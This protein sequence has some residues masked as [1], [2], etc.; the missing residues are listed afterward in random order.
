MDDRSLL[1]A[2]LGGM[3]ALGVAMALVPVRGEVGNV[4]VALGLAL[5][6]TAAGAFGRRLG[7]SVTAAVAA[8]SFAFF[9][10][11]PYDTL[12]IDAFRDVLTVVLLFALGVVTGD[13]SARLRRARRQRPDLRELRRLHRVASRAAS[14]DTVEDLTS[15][16]CAELIG[17]LVLHDCWYEDAPFLAE[18][19]VLAA[20]GTFDP[21]VYRWTGEDFG[22]PEGAACILVE[23][24]GV[25]VGRLVLATSP[26]APAPVD[27]R[28]VACALVDQLRVALAANAA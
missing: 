8:V 23:V 2:S 12:H 20:D 6:V 22:L 26:T 7:G 9:H 18:L 21:P 16:V 13:L 3:T 19:P 10:T 27:R 17:L 15:Q 24:R 5:V 11:E 1:G 4:N 28:L 25:V 14:G